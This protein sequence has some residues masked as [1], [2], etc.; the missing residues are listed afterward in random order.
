[1]LGMDEM[2]LGKTVTKV[3]RSHFTPA[4]GDWLCTGFPLNN[5]TPC[6]RHYPPYRTTHVRSETHSLCPYG[7]AERLQSSLA[8]LIC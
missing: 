2:F 6:I 5:A 8:V 1:V 3:V 7:F 4:D